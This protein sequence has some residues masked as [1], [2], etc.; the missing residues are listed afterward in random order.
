MK[1]T[2]GGKGTKLPVNL[3]KAT[4]TSST[5]G[6][7][8]GPSTYIPRN[9]KEYNR[10]GASARQKSAITAGNKLPVNIPKKDKY[11]VLQGRRKG[12]GLGGISSLNSND[13]RTWPGQAPR[14]TTENKQQRSKVRAAIFKVKS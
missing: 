7:R 9:Q 14:G 10:L 2:T 5:L 12:Y 8:K 13:Y 3:P 4:A 1:A 6:K 11:G